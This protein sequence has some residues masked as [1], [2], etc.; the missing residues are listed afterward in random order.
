MAF[1]IFFSL[2]PFACS[3]TWKSPTGKLTPLV[4]CTRAIMT[5]LFPFLVFLIFVSIQ[6]KNMKV[7]MG[8]IFSRRFPTVFNPIHRAAKHSNPIPSLFCYEEKKS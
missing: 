5:H 7:K 1:V 2:P 4:I 3:Q 6:L 8:E